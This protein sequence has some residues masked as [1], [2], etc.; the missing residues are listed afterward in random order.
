MGQEDRKRKAAETMERKKRNGKKKLSIV[1][2]TI[3]NS[4][5]LGKA[6]VR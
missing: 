1:L 3:S 2:H 5:F 4:A 6:R